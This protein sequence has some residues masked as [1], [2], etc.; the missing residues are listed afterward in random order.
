MPSISYKMEEDNKVLD[1]DLTEIEKE[2]IKIGLSYIVFKVKK[3]AKYDF[4]K[5]KNDEKDE[6]RYSYNWPYD[7]C[8]LVELFK[9]DIELEE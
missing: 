4:A 5:H 2:Q 6:V 9:I 1:I 3:R 8:S 7:Y